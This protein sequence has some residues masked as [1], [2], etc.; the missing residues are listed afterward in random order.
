L[1]DRKS[2]GNP[3]KCRL[4][5]FS[6]FY[7]S[8]IN[9]I[10]GNKNG[11]I[12]TFSRFTTN[13]FTDKTTSYHLTQTPTNQHKPEPQSLLNQHDLKQFD[14]IQ[15]F[16]P[17][18]VLSA[19]KWLPCI[20]EPFFVQFHRP[21]VAPNDRRKTTSASLLLT[22]FSRRIQVIDI[23]KITHFC[24]LQFD[25]SLSCNQLS[26]NN[27]HSTH[28]PASSTQRRLFVDFFQGHLDRSRGHFFCID[29]RKLFDYELLR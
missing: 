2:I 8:I 16:L 6:L 23:Q 14:I 3:I 18:L 11:Q 21:V 9:H 13:R 17:N 12:I 19:R 22:H 20:W 27:F 5:S 15:T 26:I 25:R 7:D 28:R 29:R 4:I 10:F 1:I 24:L